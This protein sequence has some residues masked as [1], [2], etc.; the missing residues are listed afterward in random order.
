[1]KKK[2]AQTLRRRIPQKDRRSQSKK[3]Q[4]KVRNW[5]EY[6]E[7]LVQRGSL[8]FWIDKG[9]IKSYKITIV[10]N[11][12][13]TTIKRGRPY[14]YAD[15]LIE[16]V[17][18]LGKTFHQRLRQVEGFVRSVFRMAKIDLHVPD[19]T[20]LSRRG[21][22]LTVTLPRIPKDAV[23]AI[24]DSTGLKVFGEGEWKVRQHGVSKR[25]TWVK[26]HLSVDRD[27]EIR[28]VVASDP[29]MDDAQA[30]IALLKGEEDRIDKTINDGGYD[31]RKFYAACETRGIPS[32]VIPPRQGARIWRHGNSAG[33]PLARDANLRLI[34]QTSRKRWKETSGYY[35]RARVENTMFRYKTILG[36][37]LSARIPQTQQTE[38]LVGCKI[39]N[40]M[41][42]CGMPQSYAVT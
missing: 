17:L 28:V 30:G 5:H 26:L 12:K 8:D 19:F 14:Q 13:E 11:G 4:Y 20:T 15:S 9:L 38:V 31:Q 41:Q 7:S 27:G 34:R 32:V 40:L 22:T 21:R 23:V 36:D 39:L 6:N 3:K 16:T 33:P 24:L 35:Q 10:E 37:H 42:S 2:T 1:M 25:R 18:M 29:S